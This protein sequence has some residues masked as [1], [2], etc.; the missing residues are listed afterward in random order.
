MR[1]LD[2]PEVRELVPEFVL[3]VLDGDARAD[4]VAHIDHCTACRTQVTELS[5]TADAMLLLAPEAEPPPDFERRVVARLTDDRRRGR[6]R[7]A[8]VVALVAAAAVILSVVTV[9]V[10]DSARSSGTAGAAVQT[11]PM[12]G[13]NGTTV[14]QVDVVDNGRSLGLALTVNYALPDGAYRVVLAPETL[15]RSVLGTVPV[16]DGRGAWAGVAPTGP[17]PVAL[18]LVD[19]QGAVPCSADLPRN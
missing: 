19:D 15:P 9:R 12:V 17:G 2:C 18:E 10:I 7:T 11:V 13:D 4:V 3:G 1:A 16:R 8:K 14:G 5:E 6:W